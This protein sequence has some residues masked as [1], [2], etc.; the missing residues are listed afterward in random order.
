MKISII[1]LQLFSF[2]YLQENR[3]TLFQD[4]KITYYTYLADVEYNHKL[5]FESDRVTWIPVKANLTQKLKVDTKFDDEQ[6]REY[7]DLKYSKM[8]KLE[9][10]LVKEY[11]IIN[12]YSLIQRSQVHF[13]I[14]IA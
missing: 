3:L 12:F 13:E 8:K 11:F 6:R 10:L 2:I 5:K 14:K 1:F 9:V 7:Q 4:I